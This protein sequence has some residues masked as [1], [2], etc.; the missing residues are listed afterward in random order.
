M[1][2]DRGKERATGVTRH[3]P[4]SARRCV[5]VLNEGNGN[6]GATGSQTSVCEEKNRVYHFHLLPIPHL[7]TLPIQHPTIL[8]VD[9]PQHLEMSC[10][11]TCRFTPITLWLT[12]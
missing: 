4:S 7:C 8:T 12:H 3:R 9:S 1:R 2:V 5:A 6:T 11:Q 10:K